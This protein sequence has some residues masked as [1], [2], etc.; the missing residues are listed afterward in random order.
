MQFCFDAGESGTKEVHDHDHLSTLVSGLVRLAV[1]GVPQELAGPKI[2]V[3]Q[4]GKE[5][6]VFALSD[7][8]WHCT[9]ASET[10]L[11]GKGE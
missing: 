5:H 8:I 9:H 1:D 7:V 10:A 4:A 6:E 2:I 3:I 11:I